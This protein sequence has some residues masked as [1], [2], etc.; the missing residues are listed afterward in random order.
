MR[1]WLRPPAIV[2]LSLSVG[3]IVQAVESSKRSAAAEQMMHELR[4]KIKAEH[5]QLPANHWGGHHAHGRLPSVELD[6]APRSG[7]V[8]EWR[9]DLGLRD[10]NYGSVEERGHELHLLVEQVNLRGGSS[11]ISPT[12]V[13]VRWGGRASMPEV[14]WA[15]ST[16]KR[17]NRP[18]ERP[19]LPSAAAGSPG[20]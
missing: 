2:L 12:L 10:R 17:R 11:G 5:D 13:P 1:P 6:I 4:Q 20:P 8:F 16:V 9:G 7:F 3:G 19:G 14:G 18:L 15:L